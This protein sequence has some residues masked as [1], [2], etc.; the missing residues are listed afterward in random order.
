VRICASRLPCAKQSETL[1]ARPIVAHK[2]INGG[3]YFPLIF[4][5]LHSSSAGCHGLSQNVNIPSKS[6]QTITQKCPFVIHGTHHVRPT[7]ARLGMPR[8]PLTPC[9][10]GSAKQAPTAGCCTVA[11]TTSST[12][13]DT[14]PSAPSWR[15]WAAP[16]SA[17]CSF[18]RML[19]WYCAAAAP[20]PPSGPGMGDCA[21]P[22]HQ[23]RSNR[24]R[25][26]SRF[27][28]PHDG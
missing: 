9:A 25:R 23:T 11:G 21:D 26:G 18:S 20:A 19:P 7:S 17:R 15:A 22:C 12:F 10:N 1:T 3:W 2:S 4:S 13:F 24:R 6:A 16:S 5:I 8:A 14:M 28:R 27:E